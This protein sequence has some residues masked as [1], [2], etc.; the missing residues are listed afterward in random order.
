MWQLRSHTMHAL[1]ALNQVFGRRGFGSISRKSIQCTVPCNAKCACQNLPI[2]TRRCSVDLYFIIDIYVSFNTAFY[3]ESRRSGDQFEALDRSGALVFDKKVIAR[4]YLRSWFAV[5]LIS[6]LPVSYIEYFL[7]SA[8]SEFFDEKAIKLLRLLRI[9][10][11]LRLAR[12]TRL[13][14]IYSRRFHVLLQQLRIIKLVVYICF[15]SHWIGC[16]WYFIGSIGTAETNANGE[17]VQGWVLEMY[18]GTEYVL[19]IYSNI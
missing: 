5:D 18:N 3:D 6:C 15:L 13:F 12:I 10:K 4:R 14:H 16:A 17:T 8:N 1:T 7:T 19:R 11:L 2:N 9:F